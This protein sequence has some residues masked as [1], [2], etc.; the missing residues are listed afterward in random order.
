[1]NYSLHKKFKFKYS[2]NQL[3][4]KILIKLI[5]KNEIVLRMINV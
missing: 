1:M 5:I 4:V 2:S 3:L